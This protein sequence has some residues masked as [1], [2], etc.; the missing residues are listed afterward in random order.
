MLRPVLSIASP[1]PDYRQ[2]AKKLEKY[3]KQ[4]KNGEILLYYQ[5][6]IDLNLLPG[7]L[8]CWT[9]RG[10]QRKVMTPGGVSSTLCK[11]IRS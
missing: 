5:D 9:L 6:E 2:K 7:I 8:R 3:Q 11:R 10:S 1:D 4:A